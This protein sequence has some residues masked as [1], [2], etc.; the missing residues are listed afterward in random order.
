[1][2]S[3]LFILLASLAS[4]LFILPVERI[5]P[6]PHIIEE[7]VKFSIILCA[8]H[9]SGPEV[10]KITSGPGVLHRPFVLVTLSGVLFAL[11][12]SVLYLTNIATAGIFTS[13]L[14]RLLATGFLH[15]GTMLIMFFCAKKGIFGALFGLLIAVFAHYAY[16]QW[17][18]GIV[19]STLK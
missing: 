14:P 5:F 13:L 16:N 6:H 2:M 3:S 17:A 19:F 7:L 1:M 12:E 11:S 8:I 18:A 15:S 10:S 4:P 9:K